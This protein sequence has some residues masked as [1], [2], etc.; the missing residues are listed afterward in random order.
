MPTTTLRGTVPLS[1]EPRR[2]TLP[3]GSWG[4]FLI[5]YHQDMSD[6]CSSAP[7]TGARLAINAPDTTQAHVITLQTHAACGQLTT[8]PILPA[9]LWDSMG[10]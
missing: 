9:S 5:S 10:M 1:H 6:T 4:W 2:V 7:R 8:S 3:T